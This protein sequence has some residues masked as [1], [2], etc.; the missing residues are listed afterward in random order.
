MNDVNKSNKNKDGKWNERN[1]KKLIMKV[2]KERT[3]SQKTTLIKT[4]FNLKAFDVLCH[5][6]ILFDNFLKLPFFI[7]VITSM[8]GCMWLTSTYVEDHAMTLTSTPPNSQTSLF[9]PLSTLTQYTTG[10]RP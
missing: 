6:H 4:D 7:Y 3:K 1:K 10:L 2:S 8:D 9:F 5:S